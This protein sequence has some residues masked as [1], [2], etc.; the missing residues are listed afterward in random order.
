MMRLRLVADDL[1]GALDAA[2]QFAGPGSEIPVFLADGARDPLAAFAIDADTRERADGEAAAAAARLAPI[3]APSAGVLSFKKVD[4]LLRGHPGL[5][6]AVTLGAVAARRCVIAPAFPFH[7]RATQGGRQFVRRGAS[8]VPVGEDLRATLGSH[9]IAVQLKRPGEAVPQGVSLWDAESDD[10]LRRIAV[11]GAGLGEPVLWCGSAGLA[12]AL[13]PSTPPE[14]SAGRLERPML[15]IFGSDDP[16]TAAQ[17]A[18][19]GGVLRLHSFGAAQLRR[20]SERLEDAGLCL[21]RLEA[22][23]GTSRSGASD[24]IARAAAELT[25]GAPQPR[26]LLVA[27]GE[28]LRAVCRSL[29]NGRLDVEGQ[30]FPG[31]PVSRMVGGRWGGVRVISKSGAFGDER[32]VLRIVSGAP[33]A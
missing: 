19:C 13:A 5:E 29:G 31:V 32:L 2:A 30:V 27:G 8:W 14:V 4:S 26:S 1:T 24:L 12:S 15:G 7:G 23:P 33:A 25:R 21:V 3:L 18:A 16:A 10:D 6:L 9:G 22:P 20:V 28:T 17:L 11:S